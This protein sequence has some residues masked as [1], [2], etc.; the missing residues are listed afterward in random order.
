VKFSDKIRPDTLFTTFHHP[1]SRINYLF[2]DE[3][4]A[5]ILTAAFKSIKVDVLPA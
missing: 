1:T 4:D 3:S 2:G 5:L